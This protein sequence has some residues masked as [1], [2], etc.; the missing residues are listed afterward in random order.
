M[1][2]AGK[3]AHCFCV[4]ALHGHCDS[5]L[6]G[7]GATEVADTKPELRESCERCEILC[8]QPLKSCELGE[9][10]ASHWR[11]VPPSAADV[12]AVCE[13]PPASLMR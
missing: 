9:C 3:F 11:R 12:P 4:D 6:A 8:A 1:E 10:R 7:H 13:P 5:A 2:V